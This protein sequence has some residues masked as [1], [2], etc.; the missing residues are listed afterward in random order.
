[1]FYLQIN[2]IVF[3]ATRKPAPAHAKSVNIIASVAKTRVCLFYLKVTLEIELA[4]NIKHET[5]KL[6]SAHDQ[7]KYRTSIQ[8]EVSSWRNF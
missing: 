7:L 1:M 5:L 4:R 3:L 6:F 8:F 2:C